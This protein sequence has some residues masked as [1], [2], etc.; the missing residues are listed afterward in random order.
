[1]YVGWLNR[2]DQMIWPFV[3]SLIEDQLKKQLRW[4][5]TDSNSEMSKYRLKTLHCPSQTLP[6]WVVV[7]ICVTF[8]V[9]IV[10]AESTDGGAKQTQRREAIFFYLVVMDVIKKMKCCQGSLKHCTIWVGLHDTQRFFTV[11]ND[12]KSDF[13][14]SVDTCQS[15]S[16]K[17]SEVR[18][19]T[20]IIPVWVI[21]PQK[22]DCRSRTIF[23]PRLE[24][25]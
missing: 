8:A 11:S 12:I 2:R 5:E 24:E 25:S 13:S 1:M 6:I 18:G 22:H 23:H 15:R 17:N 3:C 7:C 16:A 20:N 9:A 19:V 10:R 14:H 4:G 21:L